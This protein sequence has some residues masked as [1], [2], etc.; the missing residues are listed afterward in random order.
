MALAASITT[1]PG[2]RGTIQRRAIAFVII[3]VYA[4][5][6]GSSPAAG[7]PPHSSGPT[8]P[9]GAIAVVHPTPTVTAGDGAAPNLV[10][11]CFVYGNPFPQYSP[12]GG[13]YGNVS[14]GAKLSCQG[15]PGAGHFALFLYTLSGHG[16][17][18]SK[19]L[20]DSEPWDGIT[21]TDGGSWQLGCMGNVST[22]WIFSVYA[23]Y[24]GQPY[25]PY[26]AWSPVETIPCG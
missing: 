26:P 20:E 25:T 11:T 4:I 21:G 15:T 6:A 24:D 8:L 5:T 13:R 18:E 7:S 22:R 10:V 1:T 3:A 2:A 12:G 23:L 19:F 17:N 9:P 14:F 16:D